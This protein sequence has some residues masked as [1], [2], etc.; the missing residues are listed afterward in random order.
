MCTETICM[1]GTRLS[2]LV[3][4]RDRADGASWREF[5]AIYQPLIFGYLRGLGLKEH[6]AHDLTQEVF[7]RLL[8]ILPTFELDRKRGRFRTY[9]WRLTYNTLI[10]RARRRKVRDRAEDEWVRRFRAADE[11][12][13]RKLEDEWIRRHRRRILEVVL[14]RVRAR[15]SPTS[16]A[17]FERRL[18]QGR[19]APEVAAELGIKANVVYVYASRVLKEVRRGCAEIEEE[20][21]DGSDPD[22]P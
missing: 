7:C 17:C 16:W 19:S 22:L 10:D 4:V 18:V 1:S 2:L 8:V 13:S 20:L 14:P 12:E 9:L 6:D 5:T 21:G 15:V 11:S 3:R